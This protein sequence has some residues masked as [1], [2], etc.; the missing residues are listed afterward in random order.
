[1]KENKGNQSNNAIQQTKQRLNRKK[2]NKNNTN[3]TKDGKI[4][5]MQIYNNLQVL[6][7]SKV[8]FVSLSQLLGCPLFGSNSGPFRAPGFIVSLVGI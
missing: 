4:V 5:I 8:K 1:M 2:R 3:K 7:S 6:W